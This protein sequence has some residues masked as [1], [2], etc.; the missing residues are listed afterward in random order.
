[1]SRSSEAEAIFPRAPDPEAS[2]RGA[3]RAESLT[4]PA[5]LP[6][7]ATLPDVTDSDARAR[8]QAAA[9]RIAGFAQALSAG[10]LV[11]AHP[12]SLKEAHAR[13]HEAAAQW[14]A[15]LIKVPRVA[16]GYI[17][18]ALKLALHVL[19]WVTETPA[20]FIAAATVAFLAWYFL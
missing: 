6:P 12:V 13:V 2:R 17:Y 4:L 20:R 9:Q 16:W 5:P 1:M 19:D 3:H 14:D 7:V 11:T 8:A 18:L 15:L 10:A